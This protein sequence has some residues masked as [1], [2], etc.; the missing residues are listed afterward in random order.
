VRC[1]AHVAFFAGR[2]TVSTRDCAQARLSAAS[3]GRCLP[4]DD[5]VSMHM[6]LHAVMLAACMRLVGKFAFPASAHALLSVPQYFFWP[7]T[8][9]KTHFWP[10]LVCAVTEQS[11]SC[12][13]LG[14]DSTT[15]SCLVGHDIIIDHARCRTEQ[16]LAPL[17]CVM[18]WPAIGC[19]HHM[20]HDVWRPRFPSAA[21][22]F[23]WSWQ[24]TGESSRPSTPYMS[25]ALI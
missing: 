2:S 1:I 24:P 14:I 19:G 5:F 22:L 18:R 17:L 16:R 15:S 11:I 23:V 13:G 6:S 8:G 10:V 3:Q 9:N 20:R 4:G 21:E 25:D 7:K 12:C